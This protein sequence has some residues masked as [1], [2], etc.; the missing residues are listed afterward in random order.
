MAKNQQITSHAY[1]D[2][3]AFERLMLLIATLAQYPGVGSSDAVEKTSGQQHHDALIEVQTRLLEIANSMGIT[4]YT[5]ALPTIRKDLTILR[6]WK[7]L[8]KSRYRWGYY[9][10]MGALGREELQV[11]LNA[12]HS[13]AE[14]QEDPQIRQ[15][16]QRLERRLRGL[17][18]SNELFYPVRTHLDRTIVYTDPEEMMALSKYRGTVYDKL[19]AL[20]VA[21]IQGQAIELFRCRN[22]YQPGNTH[23]IQV[24]PLQL[25]YSDIAWYLLHEDLQNGH[26]A[27]SRLDRLSDHFRILDMKYRG[28]QLQRESLK[29]AHQLL[30]DGWGLSLG[31]EE[32]QCL[33]RQG[34]IKLVEVIVRFFPDVMAFILEGE[35]RHPTQEIKKGP[36][37]INGMSMYIEYSVKLPQRSLNE[38]CY[39]VC[40]FMGNAQ[41]ISPPE[42]IEKHEKM[43][44]DLLARYSSV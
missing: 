13:Q 1:S 7:I 2:R 40:R 44:S 35:K 42:L 9:L 26:L 12:L 34:Q 16:Y 10:G 20:Q 23:K 4:L 33:E 11:A 19:D 3:A 28:S 17:H 15:I 38:F 30:E 22:P 25:V 36:K 8:N 5:C 29:V 32:D 24:Y 6:Q 31:T 37:A 27:L 41:F 14:Y 21:I 18:L 39:W 43:A